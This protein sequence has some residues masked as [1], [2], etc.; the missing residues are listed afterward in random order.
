MRQWESLYEAYH[1]PG[2]RVLYQRWK[3]NRAFFEETDGFGMTGRDTELALRAQTDL[4]RERLDQAE[5]AWTAAG[6]PSRGRRIRHYQKRR[7]D[8]LKAFVTENRE[9]EGTMIF[10]GLDPEN[11]AEVE[12]FLM[13]YRSDE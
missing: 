7:M 9:Y 1:D 12:A 11:D 3:R 13:H 6:S 8:F 4:A 5:D 10:R 2:V